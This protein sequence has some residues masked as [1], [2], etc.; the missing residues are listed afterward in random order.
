MAIFLVSIAGVCAS[1][2]NDTSMAN[3]DSNQIKLSS[4]NEMSEDNLQTSEENNIL[5]LND[6]ETV[7]A[8][9][10]SERL[11]EGNG[12]YSDLRNDIENGGNLTKSYYKYNKSDGN[13]I[14]ITTPNMTIN[15]NG[16]IIDMDGRYV[17]PFYVNASG[18]TIKNLTIQNLGPCDGSIYFNVNSGTVENC[19]FIDL[20]CSSVRF[21]EQG[22][23]T[24]CNFSHTYDGTAVDMGS[25]SITN[26][27]FN[28]GRGA[29]NIGSGNVTN[30]T[31]I[32]HRKFYQN[33]HGG[34]IYMGSGNVTNCNFINNH[35]EQ[36]DGGAIYMGSG[37]VTNCNFTGN[38]AIY[39]WGGAIFMGS[40]NVTNCNFNNNYGVYGG[41]VYFEGDGEAINCKFNNNTS[42]H[43][44]GAIYGGTADTCIFKTG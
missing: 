1:D 10:D 32:D 42:D 4:G 29:I 5:T 39:G 41:G 27:N 33:M 36:S 17:T 18:V 11:S 25:G 9:T 6:D 20:R 8:Q 19:S 43:S 24:N 44:S 35:V 7:S 30:C 13:S 34:A 14:I 37:N 21:V 26:C 23:V 22:T 28:N 31:F 2:A 3:E 40:G 38:E 12:T 15:G 16:A